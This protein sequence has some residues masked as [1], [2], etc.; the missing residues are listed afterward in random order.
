MTM[1]MIVEN[2]N[3]MKHNSQSTDASIATDS[4]RLKNQTSHNPTVVSHY[5]KT[6]FFL[7]LINC[8]MSGSSSVTL[9]CSNILLSWL[10]MNPMLPPL[11]HNSVRHWPTDLIFGSN[12]NLSSKW[13]SHFSMC[14]LMASSLMDQLTWPCNKW[15]LVFNLLINCSFK[16]C[17]SS[18]FALWMTR[19]CST[20]RTV[21]A[22]LLVVV[23]MT[24]SD[25]T[26]YSN[27]INS[28]CIT[29]W[30]LSAAAIAGGCCCWC[31][32]WCDDWSFVVWILLLLLLLLV[33]WLLLL[34]FPMGV[35][36]DC[37]E[38]VIT[39][40]QIFV[41]VVVDVKGDWWSE[42]ENEQQD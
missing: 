29:A 41:V 11:K 12:N 34:L 32:C 8:W 7:F 36:F 4:S 39:T 33:P 5:P 25:M 3:S 42:C 30:P 14:N 9:N 37:V 40:V 24:D 1:T 16:Y 6:V 15:F 20:C 35:I 2:Y 28:P 31:W 22:E 17:F 18:C 10:M 27:W 19:N 38:Y 13:L 23:E 21:M 26:R